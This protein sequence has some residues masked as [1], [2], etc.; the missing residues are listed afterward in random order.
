M[1]L[2]KN[3]EEDL[4]K[5]LEEDYLTRC[6]TACDRGGYTQLSIDSRSIR[7]DIIKEYSDNDKR[8]EISD[9]IQLLEREVFSFLGDLIEKEKYRI[10]DW[11][12]IQEPEL[13]KR[14]DKSLHKVYN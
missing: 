1:S 6:I 11:P 2:I 8:N 14:I 3:L 9:L 7:D 4:V 5:K 10:F 13:R 12:D